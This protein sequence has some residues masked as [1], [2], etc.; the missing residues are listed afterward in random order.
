[1]RNLITSTDTH[2]MNVQKHDINELINEAIADAEEL[3][4]GQHVQLTKQLLNT[5]EEVLADK[6]KLKKA[7]VNVIQN[8][9]EA[10][11]G[12]PKLI[13][14]G[15]AIKNG[16]LEIGIKDNGTGIDPENVSKI[17]EPFFTTKMR[18]VGLGLTHAQRILMSHNG[19][20]KVESSNK[21]TLLTMQVPQDQ[22][23]QS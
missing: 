12:F 23:P 14:V 22:E 16:T 2:T 21:G 5:D 9:L 6:P 18:A 8:A 20:I 1:V 10:I 3:I 4:E 11:N 17:F 7:I 15:A 19:F 13:Y